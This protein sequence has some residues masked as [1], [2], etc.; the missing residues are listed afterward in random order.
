MMKQFLS[1]YAGVAVTLWICILEMP[2]LNICPDTG[3][4]NRFSWISLLLQTNTGM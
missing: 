1:E 4:P 3:C 2:S